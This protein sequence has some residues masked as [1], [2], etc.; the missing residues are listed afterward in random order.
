MIDGPTPMETIFHAIRA[1]HVM[2]QDA[3]IFAPDAE[4]LAKDLR[5]ILPECNVD[6]IPHGDDRFSAWV[7]APDPAKFLPEDLRAL[8]FTQPWGWL[9]AHGHKDIENRKPGFSHKSFRGPFLI[10]AAEKCTAKDFA[11]T[12][13]IVR[14]VTGEPAPFRIPAYDRQ[15]RGGIIGVARMVDIIPPWEPD[16]RPPARKWHFPYQWGFVVKDA[17]PLP[18][19]PCGGALGFWKVTPDIR[20]HVERALAT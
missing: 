10:H 9:V 15:E 5:A 6:T 1:H 3:R 17:R 14:G 16:G 13:R 12:L 4:A 8:S 7:S 2:G 19:I 11:N 20:A 18:F